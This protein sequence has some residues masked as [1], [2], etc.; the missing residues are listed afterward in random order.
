MLTLNK[1]LVILGSTASGKS[2]LALKLAKKYNGEII[3]ADSR[4]IYRE[5]N[6]ATAKPYLNLNQKAKTKHQNY[7]LKTRKDK[8]TPILIKKIHHYLI[9]VIKPNQQFSVAEYKK[10]TLKIIRDI[11]DRGKLPILVGGTGLYIST[12]V[13]N[14]EIPKAPPNNKIRKRL[15]KYSKKYLFAK[16]SKID[17]KSSKIIGPHN[18]RKLIRALEVFEITGKP[19]SAQQ[20]KGKPLFDI[21]QIGIKIDR[22]KLYKKIDNR[23]NKMIKNGLIGET[24]RLL[25][26]Y[27]FDLPAM[28]GIGYKEIGQY[29]NKKSS[30]NEATQKIKFRTHQYARRQMTWFKKDKTIR[31]IEN[32]KEIKET[33]DKFLKNDKP[34]PV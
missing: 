17:S 20:T 6:I 8:Q 34:S 31:W 5:M 19:F 16:L 9:D 12:I 24:E 14:L 15:E 23:V 7:K 28:S 29:L 27:G 26:K 1:L 3:N 32:Y 4:Q 11:Q 21:L 33:L 2:E 22:E 18:K 25:K 30:L 10:L 13:D